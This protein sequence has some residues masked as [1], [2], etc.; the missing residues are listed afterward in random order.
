MSQRDPRVSR[1][2]TAQRSEPSWEAPTWPD[3]YANAR[4]GPASAAVAS[5][6]PAAH[7]MRRATLDFF[8]NM[9][10]LVFVL[11]G[12]ILTVAT[13]LWAHDVSHAWRDVTV[14]QRI[15][16]YATPPLTR[17]MLT[18]SLLGDVPAIAIT[19]PALVLLLLLLRQPMQA[20]TLLMSVVGGIAIATSFKPLVAR[21]GPGATSPPTGGLLAF[22][23]YAFPSG[24]AVYFLTCFVP[25]AWFLWQ[26]RPRGSLAWSMFATIGRILCCLAFLALAVLG[27]LSQ[28]YLGY[29][30]PT[31]VIGGYAIG[32][33]WSCLVLLVYMRFR[34]HAAL[35]RLAGA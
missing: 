32:G 16:S 28:I 34:S 14:E 12:L 33:F 3:P 5:T 29:H 18:V 1:R 11:V 30:W 13:A 4:P 10:L 20:V 17:F 31:D 25:I 24:H 26:W 6:A 8:L 22:N 9:L 21:L 27:G 15:Q 7:E 23:H 35:A 19:V 2:H